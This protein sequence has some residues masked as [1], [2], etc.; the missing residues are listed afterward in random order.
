MA[1]RV[2]K[3]K[4]S[5]RNIFVKNRIG[6]DFIDSTEELQICLYRHFINDSDVC[7]ED[8]AANEE[9]INSKYGRVVSKFETSKGEILIITSGL[10]NMDND[11]TDENDINY[12]NTVVMFAD[13]Y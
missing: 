11:P 1:N 12:Y 9:A 4:F 13:E 5:T 3:E 7:E 6:V 10:E 8:I 2:V